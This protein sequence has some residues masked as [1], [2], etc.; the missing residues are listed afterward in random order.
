MTLAGSIAPYTHDGLAVE[1]MVIDLAAAASAS[2]AQTPRGIP[3]R[4][5]VWHDQYTEDERCD[6][7]VTSVVEWVPVKIGDFPAVANDLDRCNP[8]DMDPRV[9]ISLR[10]CAPMPGDHGNVPLA[11]EGATA[12]DLI[13]DARALQCGVMATWPGIVQAVY[14]PT[15][16]V[17]YGSMTPTSG[18]GLAGWD[19]PVLVEVFGCRGACA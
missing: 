10:R 11:D 2:L 7:I 13:V 16:R 19:W 1:Q 9:M 15:V 18:G 3:Q 12:E 8:L 5:G 17:Q 14:G 4:A 6:T